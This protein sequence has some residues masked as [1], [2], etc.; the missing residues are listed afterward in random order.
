M[1]GAVAAVVV[2]LVVLVAASDRFVSGAAGLSL[3]FRVSPVVVGAV[4]IGF[5]TSAPE[6]LTSVFAAAG[7]SH[8][9]AMGNIVGSN[10]AN[11]TLVL[12]VVAALAAPAIGAPTLR[13]EV[14]LMVAGMAGFAAVVGTFSRPAAGALLVGFVVAMALVLRVSRGDPLLDSEV[15][16]ELEEELVRPTRSLV[17]TT[18]IGLAGT[19]LGA[20]LLVE[21]ARS[22]ADRSGLE[23][24]L[25]GF[26]LVALGT[27]LPEVVTAVQA[28]RRGAADLAIGNV[29]GSNLFN[30]LAIAGV[31]GLVA[32]GAT[33]GGVVAAAWVSVGV[34]VLVGLLM[35]TGRRL[36]PA[37]GALLLLAYAATIPVVA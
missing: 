36:A 8:D 14:P 20:H 37:E 16:Q 31:A 29:L 1:I 10:L 32:P 22:I 7:G 34:A 23:E 19:V 12:G 24:G 35:L 33:S 3:R 25:V 5:G 26:T 18:A 9:I 21:G 28:S 17:I 11:L 30:S 15:Q 27:S 2:G 13:R 4:V 6:L